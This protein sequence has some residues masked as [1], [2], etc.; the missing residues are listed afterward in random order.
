V[1]DL[2]VDDVVALQ[3]EALA[4]ES[5]LTKAAKKQIKKVSA[6]IDA[7]APVPAAAPAVALKIRAVSRKGRNHEALTPKEVRNRSAIADRN[8]NTKVIMMT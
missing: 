7:S 8:C 2:V 1:V 6:Q 5:S 3:A 4:E